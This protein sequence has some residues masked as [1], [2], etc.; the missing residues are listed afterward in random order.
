MGTRV[1]S[2]LLALTLCVSWAAL[3]PATARARGDEPME[4]GALVREADR[5]DGREI[6]VSGEAIGD[7]LHADQGGVWV[8]VL[9][10]GGTAVGVWVDRDDAE[11]IQVLGDWKHRG[12]VVEVVGTFN[13]ACPRH[14]GDLDIHATT[15]RVVQPGER[16]RHDPRWWQGFAGGALI[17][18]AAGMYLLYRKRRIAVD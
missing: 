8:N 15:L 1:T 3:H 18:T 7:V 12:D 14:G 13:Q 5:Y 6:R 4:P 9:G 10:T 2:L 17:L 11:R 16:V